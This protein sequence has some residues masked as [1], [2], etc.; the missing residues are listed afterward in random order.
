MSCSMTLSRKLQENSN[1]LN[2]FP[3]QGSDNG[4]R[5]GVAVLQ[6]FDIFPE[7]KWYWIGIVA[8]MAFTILFNL[9]F[10]YAL[11]YLSREFSYLPLKCKR[12]LTIMASN[13]SNTSSHYSFREST[14][15]NI[16]GENQQC[17]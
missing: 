10:T 12:F 1:Y 4:T 9:V 3:F 6:D 17:D 11:T 2:L 16:R 7:E 5:L 15:N 8:L 14:W 13:F